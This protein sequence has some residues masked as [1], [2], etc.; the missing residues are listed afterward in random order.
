MG[1]QEVTFT[2]P[3]IFYDAAKRNLSLARE[4]EKRMFA[5]LASWFNKPR[6]IGGMEAITKKLKGLSDPIEGLSATAIILSAASLEAFIF[7]WAAD[8]R[9]IT[10]VSKHVDNLG[11]I[12]VGWSSQSL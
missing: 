10:W 1:D 11:F 7:E 9:S 5:E 4:S 3:A 6:D 2:N 12:P 8:R